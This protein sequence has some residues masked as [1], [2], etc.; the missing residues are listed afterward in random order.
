MTA[1]EQYIKPILDARVYDVARQT[2]LH[3]ARLLSEKLE[4]NILL[5]RE[6]EQDIF[7]FKCRGA[8]N[9]LF[10]L[11]KTCKLEGVVAASAGNHAQ[12]VA[13]AASKLGI[14]SIIVMPVTT[15]QIKV[16]AVI[17]LGG[18][19]VLFGDDFN[20]AFTH[21]VALGEEQNYPLIHP[22]DD[23]DT[24]AGQ[25]TIG[26]EICQQ[27]PGDMDY[28][29]LPIG[30]G[31][32]AAGVSAYMKY[33]RPNVRV[34]GVEPVD[35]ACMHAAMQ[36]G[37]TVELDQV[38]L[39]ADG[40]AVRRAGEETFRV[41]RETLDD[42]VLVTVDEMSSAIKDIFN[43]TR[44]L[45]EP[46]GALAVAGVKK[47]IKE[48][49]LQG[50]TFVAINTGA[51]INFDRLRHVAE[52]AE[53]GETRE[54][55][56]AVSIPETPGSFL[57]FCKSLGRRSVTEFNYR[58]QAGKLA[59]IFVGVE[60]DGGAT[61]RMEFQKLLEAAG[62]SVLD[63]SRNDTAKLHIRHMIGGRADFSASEELEERLYRFRFPERP[64]ALVD[65]LTRM[66][67]EWNITLFH[68]RN[69][70]AAYGRVL[71]GIQ[72][73]DDCEQD[74]ENFLDQLGFSSEEESGN[75]AFKRFL[76]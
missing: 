10:K 16:D 30:G 19:A 32:L 58:F 7:S 63:M 14:R 25:G 13:L 1:S 44:T 36:A 66:G 43:E 34:I 5:K 31:G 6:D 26:V 23:P 15:P 24:I 67:E 4:N 27:H 38:G 40:V 64:G 12:G 18:K 22:F 9:R 3:P 48:K 69:H 39:F 73:P 68:Y 46:A 59:E 47:Y 50:K 76:N 74:F 75:P 8:F 41:C 29:F 71:V 11:S 55:L 20:A 54:A 60:I 52:R 57:R 21:A 49:S 45:T 53:L 2:R 37:K 65:F 17:A 72:I 51:N 28:L 35:A 70:G 33:L 42:I 56:F 61:R 62:Y